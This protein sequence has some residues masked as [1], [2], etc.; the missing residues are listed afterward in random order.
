MAHWTGI[1]GWDDVGVGGSK[2]FGAA[3]PRNNSL[4]LCTYQFS[5]AVY[6]TAAGLAEIRTDNLVSSAGIN[7]WSL[8][9]KSLSCE[10]G[11]LL[12]ESFQ[13]KSLCSSP[14]KAC[15]LEN[16]SKG[17]LYYRMEGAQPVLP[18]ATL[19]SEALQSHFVRGLKNA[20]I[21]RA[22]INPVRTPEPDTSGKADPFLSV[23]LS[24]T[25]IIC[26]IVL[27]VGCMK[28]C[29]ACCGRAPGELPGDRSVCSLKLEREAPALLFKNLVNNNYEHTECCICM[30]E[31]EDEDEVRQIHQ[32]RHLMHHSCLVR[33]LD[34]TNSCPL[35]KVSLDIYRPGRPQPLADADPLPNNLGIEMIDVDGL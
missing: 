21:E 12:R 3:L 1:G 25:M 9:V 8:L 5:L 29:H 19:S 17:L 33:W 15:S 35:C 4:D 34:R 31:F 13:L 16:H 22:F 26:I 10:P 2:H 28:F 32:C 6:C 24:F 14:P 11:A 20:S 18:P 30:S 7:Y 27:I 23:L